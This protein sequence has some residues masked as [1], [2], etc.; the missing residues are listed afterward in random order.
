MT[1]TQNA[2]AKIAA[3]I[4]DMLSEYAAAPVAAP[5][6]A[7]AVGG[8]IEVDREIVVAVLAARAAVAAAEKA[9]KDAEAALKTLV[10]DSYVITV[11]GIPQFTFA[12]Q[13]REGIDVTLLREQEPEVAERFAR[14][15]TVRSL[16]AKPKANALLFA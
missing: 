5:A 3:R 13:D 14:T 1:K 7:P 6:V 12:P 16:L 2:A 4:A 15:T 10:G 8:T 11:N 9:K